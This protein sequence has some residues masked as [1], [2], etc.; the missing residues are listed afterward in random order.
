MVYTCILKDTYVLL[1]QEPKEIRIGDREF[2][3]QFSGEKRRRVEKWDTYQYIPLITNLRKLLN[4]STVIEQIEIC[5]ERIHADGL[6]EDICDG[7]IFTDHPLFS[8]DPFAL[9]IIAYYDELE[10]CNPLGTHV[11]CHKLGIVFYTL[12]N[13]PPQY[14]S[15]LKMINLAIVATVPIIEKH[16]LDKVLEPFITDL[17][18]LATTGITLCVQGVQRTLRGA[19]LA[20]LADNLASNDLGGFKKSFSF[21][22]RSCR[23][24][25][26]TK[27]TLTSGFVSEAYEM[28]NECTHCRQCD[29]LEGPTASHYSKTYGIN[30]RSSLLNI[31][32]YCMFG[33]GLPH[34]AMHDI[35]EGMAPLEVKLLLIQCIKDGL[36]TLEYFNN[37]LVNFAFGYSESNKPIPIL[38][39]VLHSENSIR[40]SASQ[41]SQLLR[42]LPFLVGDKIP[43]NN[44]YWLCFLILRRIIDIVL[45]PVLSDSLC[46]T[47]KLLINE[48][49]EKFVMLY[50][51]GAYIPKMHFMLHYPE[52]IKAIGP[53]VRTWTIRHEAKLH[54]FKQAAR[55]LNFKNVA[56]ALANRH[57]RWM[58][59]AQASEKLVCSSFECGPP[60]RET[61]ITLV[62]D[63]NNDIQDSLLHIVPDLSLEAVVFHPKWVK[64]DGILYQCNN[65]YLITGSD[66]LDPIFS[67]LDDLLVIGGDMCVFVVSLCNVNYYDSHY[68]AYVIN[69]T[70]HRF[71]TSILH[72]HNVYHGHKLADGQTYISLKYLKL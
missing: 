1:M 6:I 48:H 10:I 44:E 69:V 29:L 68:H 4:D 58:C 54:F 28:R 57:Q 8:Q 66:G 14:R 67:H 60:L 51:A 13:I 26:V 45:C 40:A 24:C 71:V 33:G 2:R 52:Q 59:Y 21:A 5:T 43:E 27:D 9:Q 65:V 12:A 23:T 49:H 32:F 72:D 63:E 37:R 50:G 55:L 53:M 56:Y 35:L 11:K 42:V 36:F 34:D 15:Q 38:S 19:L 7:T 16:G 39:R 20:F 62:K 17:N 64:K 3:P 30:R 47:L 18:I 22:F 41:M 61:G 70:S 46:M 31:K 25:L